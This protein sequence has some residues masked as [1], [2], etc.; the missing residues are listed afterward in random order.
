[1]GY[2][3]LGEILSDA[4]GRG[5]RRALV[6]AALPIEMRAVLAHLS[7][8]ASCPGRD[9]TIYECGI[10][11][12]A[13]QEWLVVVVET[14]AGTH[15]A[16][17]VV[18]YAHAAFG[19][20][21]LQIFIGVGGSR[22]IDAP[23][24]SVVASN[25]VYMPYSGKYGES[26]WSS[27]PRTF[28]LDN[29]LV[30][31]ARKISRDG[32]WPSR[33]MAPLR[34]AL[35]TTDAYPIAYPPRSII[36]PIVSVEAVSADPTSELEKHIAENYGDACVVEMEGYGAIFAANQERTPCILIRGV[37]DMTGADK[38]ATGDAIRQPIAACHAAAFGFELLSAWGEVYRPSPALPSSVPNEL[39]SEANATELQ[40]AKGAI[41]EPP[42]GAMT[43]KLVLNLEGSPADYP[44]ERVQALLDTIQRVA[45][46]IEIS[47][48]RSESGSFRLI[49]ED[50]SE[51][52]GK[53]DLAKLRAVLSEQMGT[54]VLGLV[55]EAEY[56]QLK[57]LQRE[58]EPASQDL[59]AWPRHLPGGEW[60]DRPELTEL[61][62]IVA[63]QSATA[64]AL[65]GPPGSGKSALLAALGRTL[66]DRGWPVLGI[67]A[68]LLD[69]GVTTEADLQARL[70]LSEK[71]GLILER[72]ARLRPVVLLIDQL[73]ALAGYLDVRTGRLSVLLNLTR[74]L[75]RTD[76]VHIVLSARQFEYEH[77]VRLRT[78]SAESLSLLLPSW[79]Q[80]LSIL[81]AKGIEAAGWP[82]DAREV[83]R[84]PQAL[85]TYLQLEGRRKSEPFVTYH[86]MLDRLWSER[87]LSGEDGHRRAQLAYEIADRMAEEESLWLA[88]ARFDNQADNVKALTAAGVLTPYSSEGSIGFTHQTLFDY[89][90]ARGFAQLQGR[91]SRYVLERQTSL[92]VRPKLW[93]ALNYLRAVEK[94]TYEA[95]LETM[96]RTPGLRRHLR[97]LLLDFIGQQREPSDREA[98]LMAEVL[99]SQVDR[100][101]GLRA[102]TGSAG[103]FQ[104]FAFS[105]IA[106]AMSDPDT[107]D[108]ATG[109]LT[110]AA[111]FAVDNVVQLITSRWLSDIANDGRVW[112]VVANSVEWTEGMLDLAVR[113]LSRTDIAPFHVNY[114]VSTIGVSCPEFALRLARARLDRELRIA[115]EEADRLARDPKPELKTLDA[116]MAWDV[117]K[118]PRGPLRKLYDNNNEW[119]A[120]PALAERTPR[121]FLEELWPWYVELFLALQTYE[122]PRDRY[123]GYALSYEA[124]LRLEGEHSLGLPE[125]AL[126]AA[127]R[128]AAERVAE[129]EPEYFLKW[130]EEQLSMDATPVHRLLAH[131][132]AGVPAGFSR[133]AL[134]YLLGDP[135]RFYLGSIEDPTSTTRRLIEAVSG[136]WSE[137]EMRQFEAAIAS[138]APGYA[139][140]ENDPEA[141]RARRRM[142]RLVKLKLLRAL[143]HHR[144]SAATRRTIAE[145]R[146]VFGDRQL[147]VR[148]SGPR[149]I[150]SIM[151]ADEIRRASDDDVINAFRTLPDATEWHHP[152]DWDKGGNVQLAREFANFAR[153][154]QDRA[155]RLIGRFE[156]EFGERAAGYAIDAMAE[157][158]E[159]GAIMK[160]F[161]DLAKRG[162]GGEEYRGSS[163]H[164]ISQLASRNCPIPPEVPQIL[165]SW[166][167]TPTRPASR[168]EGGSTPADE[169]GVTSA[170]AVPEQ[171]NDG[172]RGLEFRSVLWDYGGVMILPGGEYLVLEALIR[173]RLARHEPE[174]LIEAL[175]E[176]LVRVQ[177]PRIWQ[178][179]LN[180]FVYIPSGKPDRR[181]EFLSGVFSRY[182]QFAGSIDAARLL[183]QVHWWAPDMVR[184]ELQRW[185]RIGNARVVQAYGELVTL[186]AIQQPDLSWARLMLD[187]LKSK[188]ELGLGRV[189]AAFSAVNLWTEP[190]Y[191]EAATD[192]L[193]QLMKRYERGVWVAFFDLFRL[194]HELNPE[195]SAIALLEVMAERLP[196]APPA[197]GTFVIERL[198]SLLPHRAPLVARI[199]GALV[200]LWKEELSDMRTLGAATAPRLVDL[201]VTLHRLGPETREAGTGLLEGLIEM[202]A[203]SARQTLDEI[204]SRFQHRRSGARPH[205]PRW[206]GQQ[207]AARAPRPGQAAT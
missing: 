192:L 114:T 145:E 76:N 51:A 191:R 108:L 143:P 96:W 142:I 200:S 77:D 112:A 38:T 115:K 35:P 87:V 19:M 91:L 155:V 197:G 182:P 37:S 190:R 153:A 195:R 80:V 4:D 67:K 49:L 44:P 110:S 68:D 104:R 93:A 79:S 120:L 83:M 131:T 109:V 31:L 151:Q 194:V 119:D 99:Q 185:R 33:I 48:V 22:K 166:L 117:E 201:A 169:T 86:A 100:A 164:A 134:N 186:V 113:V 56:E 175:L 8:L 70:G 165:E 78:I 183:A 156:P 162:F 152:S 173:V 46:S 60:I 98:L 85:A 198:A 205:L 125:P 181:A 139:A 32:Q 144:V 30:G 118:N 11:S 65:I 47:I 159:P 106:D 167:A 207:R 2:R 97:L 172:K 24:G 171:D 174:L 12:G 71:P 193:C 21:E 188:E 135:R 62:R 16:Q 72:L 133:T 137:P 199:A 124:D 50:P 206:S 168:S 55:S 176:S 102:L 123:V 149:M 161:L 41:C 184:R 66:S 148:F 58:L 105:F 107:A 45:G 43:G 26:G 7:K 116:R 23:I 154:E 126:L 52:L 129:T 15:P 122:A 17:S 84:S 88:S 90:L 196:F 69:P 82:A 63:D 25:H 89:A 59:L 5:L 64:T 128:I 81:E 202:D 158:G 61:L 141:R 121:K 36:A 9:G 180:I 140:L 103:W 57:D 3:T 150:G 1:M 101:M 13:G 20:F 40:T 132:L 138:Y 29:R 14:G 18:T 160:L 39:P 42:K 95:E 92:F 170:E 178:A 179:L 74:R 75:G 73:D 136:H 157:T 203:Y 27:R 127:A 111:S 28:Q 147:G 187:E 94:S 53:V 146:R 54:S 34:G 10:F 177:D 163:A 6:V 189:G 130:M 204:D